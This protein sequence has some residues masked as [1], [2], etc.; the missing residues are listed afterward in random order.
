MWN[1]LAFLV[2]IYNR[3]WHFTNRFKSKTLLKEFHLGNNREQMFDIYTL[4]DM[5]LFPTTDERR[6]MALSVMNSIRK[7][8]F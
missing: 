2:V 5:I 7:I 8:T 1:L 3:L 6:F 4:I